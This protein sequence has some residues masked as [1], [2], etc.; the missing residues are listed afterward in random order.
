MRPNPRYGLAIIP[1]PSQT[2]TGFSPVLLLSLLINWHPSA[3][4]LSTSCATQIATYQQAVQ[5]IGRPNVRHA[6]TNIAI[7]LQRA[8]ET[9]D[10]AV[11]PE[12]F[13]ES[14]SSDRTVVASS[15]ACAQAVQKQRD[16]V[17]ANPSLLAA[18]R[19]A[20]TSALAQRW[21]TL[22]VRGGA[23]LP[24][25]RRADLLNRKR[26]LQGIADR[27]GAYARAVR[28]RIAHL[29]GYESWLDYA[30]ANRMAQNPMRIDKFLQTSID[31]IKPAAERQEA[32]LRDA[33]AASQGRRKHAMLA[34]DVPRAEYL[35]ELRNGIDE[36]ELRKS[37]PALPTH[38]KV[39]ALLGSLLGLTVTPA[40]S[41][42]MWSENVRAYRVADT[43]THRSLGTVAVDL[44]E[45]ADAPVSLHV[46]PLLWHRI[47]AI[48]GSTSP[49][50][51]HH[52]LIATFHA[53]ASALAQLLA[54]TPCS[55]L[56]FEDAVPQT[57]AHFAWNPRALADVASS[58][59]PEDLATK[60]PAMRSLH[61]AYDEYQDLLAAQADT[62]GDAYLQLW[63][64]VYAD[65]LF[66][67]FATGTELDQVTGARFRETVLAPA[68]TIAPDTE[69]LHFLGRP[70]SAD[71]FYK[72]FAP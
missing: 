68:G 14:V 20:R 18:L 6:S 42:D 21:I 44:V 41:P 13:L 29:L 19:T 57:L 46:T 35:L 11:G 39:L 32:Q 2:G 51:E 49:Y 60:I 15:H 70:M 58:R 65:D 17:V 30:L 27:S 24:P 28:D 10:D 50:L 61:S 34:G 1:Q 37:F 4:D 9:F 36:R 64:S 63:S 33:F 8:T 38:E 48:T 40:A 3:G 62:T 43:A 7:A 59:L 12:L 31:A 69:V 67:A 54:T 47:V 23:G 71:A 56:D 55:A 5:S 25:E 52:D 26:E 16:D 72:E 22:L 45:H 53:D 66:T